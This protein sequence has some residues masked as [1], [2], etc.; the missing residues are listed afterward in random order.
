MI[1]S[2]RISFCSE[3]TLG[4]CDCYPVCQL[5]ATFVTESIF[6][7]TFSAIMILLQKESSLVALEISM[8]VIKKSQSSNDSSPEVQ[9][10]ELLSKREKEV[11]RVMLDGLTNKE[12]AQKLFISYET[13]KSHRKNILSKTGSKNTAALLKNLKISDIEELK[14]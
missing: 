11:L 2:F 4:C 12:I 3:L 5:P 9:K 14:S 7:D 8:N 6:N 10:R 1:E 13:V